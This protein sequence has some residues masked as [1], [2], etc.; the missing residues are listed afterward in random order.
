[1]SYSGNIAPRQANFIKQKI[2]RP[3]RIV[4]VNE[5]FVHSVAVRN[6][7][8]SVEQPENTPRVNH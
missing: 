4:H 8:Q 3:R 7:I 6:E 2:L 1:M 5:S